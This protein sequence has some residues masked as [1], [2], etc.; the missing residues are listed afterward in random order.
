MPKLKA[1]TFTKPLKAKKFIIAQYVQTKLQNKVFQLKI[2]IKTKTYTK[3]RAIKNLSQKSLTFWRR[4]Q[5][6]KKR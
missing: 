4:K 1:L 6:V 2:W 3:I 5:S